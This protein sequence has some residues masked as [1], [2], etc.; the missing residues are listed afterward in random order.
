[1]NQGVHLLVYPVNDLEKAKERFEKFTG[2]KPYIDS[3]M[4]VG[5][6]LNGQEIGLDPNGHRVSCDGP[7]SYW[8]V[9]NI[10][11][12]LRILL[13]SGGEILQDVRDIGGGS[14]I[15]IA[16]GMD[17]NIFGLRQVAK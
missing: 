13:E 2:V 16:K 4:Y 15:A 3:P 8:D 17:G 9:D 5:Y 14:L 12:S 1:M 7:V 11:D 6:R 10:R